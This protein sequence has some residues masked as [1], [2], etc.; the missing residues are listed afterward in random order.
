[1]ENGSRPASNEA[2]QAAVEAAKRANAHEIENLKRD[3]ED[4]KRL[5]DE[6]QESLTSLSSAYNGL[7][8]EVYRLE[9]EATGLRAKLHDIADSD[10]VHAPDTATLDVAREAGRQ[11]GR[12]LAE[13]E[14]ETRMR[15]AVEAAVA[16]AA[17]AHEAELNDLLACLGQEEASKEHLFARLLEL[18]VDETA[19]GDELAKIVIGDE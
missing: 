8:A 10:D 16:E 17:S 7:E 13:V 9:S 14:F 4:F 19:L 12:R 6:R 1:M 3:L 2:L 18:G 5:A 11:E 15:D